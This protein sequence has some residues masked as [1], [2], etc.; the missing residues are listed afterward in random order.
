MPITIYFAL[1]KKCT[2]VLFIALIAL[3]TSCRSLKQ[4]TAK[5][6]SINKA[7]TKANTNSKRTPSFIDNIELK[8]NKVES[9]STPANKKYET[10]VTYTKPDELLTNVRIEELSWKQIKYAIQ[11]NATVEKLTNIALIDNMEI[12]WGTRYCLGGNTSNCIDCSGFTTAIF[13]DVYG[14]SLPR[15]AQE[16]Y[17]KAELIDIADAKEGD[18]VFF[19]H[20]GNNINHVGVYITNNKFVHASTSQGVMI[21]DL[22]D[23]YW[24]PRLK[25]VGRIN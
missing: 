17:N 6:H 2:F 24:Q 14:K 4:V 16:Q 15:T 18:L 8:G 5:D 1:V 23:K 25:G 12:W 10:K 9:K 22:N 7:N 19:S 13:K 3:A 11:L 20:N 21:S